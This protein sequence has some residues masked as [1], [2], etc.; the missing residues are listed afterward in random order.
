MAVKGKAGD[1]EEIVERVPLLLTAFSQ[2]QQHDSCTTASLD[3]QLLISALRQT[4]V[5]SSQPCQDTVTGTC[6]RLCYCV[7]ITMHLR[8][9]SRLLSLVSAS[10]SSTPLT[11][12]IRNQHRCYLQ[13][14][15]ARD[16]ECLSGCR[17]L[18]GPLKE[19]GG[20]LGCEKLKSI[21]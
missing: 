8:S 7:N 1:E 2:E 4:N 18:G 14:N 3:Q 5:L 9:Q 6:H 19:A 20:S 10:L 16:G 11:I 21:N 12:F 15:H 17:G 13:S